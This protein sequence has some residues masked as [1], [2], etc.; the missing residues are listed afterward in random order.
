MSHTSLGLTI[1]EVA[2]IQL[3]GMSGIFPAMGTVHCIRLSLVSRL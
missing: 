3:Q 2:G 1:C